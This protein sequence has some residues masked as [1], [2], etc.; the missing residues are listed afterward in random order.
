MAEWDRLT[1]QCCSKILPALLASA[2]AVSVCTA[3]VAAPAD[4]SHTSQP[5]QLA[6]IL[7]TA[8][9]CTQDLQ[10]VPIAV[11]VLGSDTLKKI[12]LDNAGD[13][14]GLIPNLHVDCLSGSASAAGAPQCAA[15]RRRRTFQLH[16][17][18]S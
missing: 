13:L 1:G 17:V 10:D 8:Q 11:S 2:I 6:E 16:H 15:V 7:V 14:G 4:P 3:Q 18:G 9:K 5:D 12:H